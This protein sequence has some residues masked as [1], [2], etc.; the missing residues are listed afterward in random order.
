MLMALS[1]LGDVDVLAFRF[2][3]PYSAPFGH[4]GATHSLVFA[5]IMGSA[6]A[7]LLVRYERRNLWR[8]AI[9]ACVVAVSHPLLDAMTDG[10]LGVALLWPFSTTRFFAPWRPIPVAPIGTRMLSSRGLHVAVIEAL[11]SMPV[12]IWALWPRPGVRDGSSTT[13]RLP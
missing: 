7:L 5:V 13:S 8:A 9:T 11:W 3:I 6:T 4:R 12:F 2:G 1:V 10:G